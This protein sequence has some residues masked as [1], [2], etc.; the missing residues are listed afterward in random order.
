MAATTVRAGRRPLMMER[1]PD[2]IEGERIM[3]KEVPGHFPEWVHRATVRKEGGSVTQVACDD[4][5]TLAYLAGQACVTPHRRLSRAD[6]PTR[7]DRLVFGLDPAGDD[8]AQV[9]RAAADL[10]ELLDEIDLPAALMT[11]GSRGLHVVVPLDGRGDTDEVRAFA[12][13]VPTRSPPGTRTG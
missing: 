12:R 13:E 2:G 1:R 11:T 10:R 7:P 4:T 6:R 3:Q 5:A 9:R 8:F